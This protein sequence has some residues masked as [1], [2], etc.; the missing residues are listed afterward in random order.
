[1]VSA[2]NL[3]SHTD[4]KLPFTVHTDD[5]DKKL[6]TIIRHKNKPIAFYQ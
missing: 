4:W 3:L 2:D 5:S 6:G 1:M